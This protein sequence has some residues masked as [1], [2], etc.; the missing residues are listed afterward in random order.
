MAGETVTGD[1]PNEAEALAL[2]CAGL[3]G[4]RDHARAHG[5]TERLDR[6]AT[7]VREGGSALRAVRKW[8]QDGTTE[9]TR[10]WSGRGSPGMVG[11]PGTVRAPVVSAGTYA[12]PADRCDRVAGRDAQGHAPVCHALGAT[13]R[14]SG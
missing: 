9:T 1:E 6:D 12:C 3:P 13:M 10:S 2:W 14:P 4:L 8:L 5:V 11:I 7:R